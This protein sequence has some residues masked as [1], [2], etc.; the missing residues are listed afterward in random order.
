M[1]AAAAEAGAVLSEVGEV[2]DGI[3]PTKETVME[4]MVPGEGW[5]A[6]TTAE[7]A[8]F[9]GAAVFADNQRMV[10]MCNTKKTQ[11][12]KGEELVIYSRWARSEKKDKMKIKTL[13]DYAI[14]VK[15]HQK[16]IWRTVKQKIKKV[17]QQQFDESWEYIGGKEEYI[18]L[19]NMLDKLSL[20]MDPPTKKAKTFTEE[21][22]T[23]IL[24][25]LLPDPEAWVTFLFAW[26]TSCRIADVEMLQWENINRI[27]DRVFR[28]QWIAK[29]G[30][31]RKI[32]VVTEI[33]ILNNHLLA[34]LGAPGAP[35]SRIFGNGSVNRVVTTLTA[36][37]FTKHSVKRSSL[38]CLAN[39]SFPW[40]SLR[41]Q[42]RHQTIR[43]TK[44][45]L[46]DTSNPDTF[47]TRCAS[48]SL[49]S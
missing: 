5:K 41:A 9:L 42:A 23:Q 6:R 28:V 38:A 46:N 40:E 1:E 29:E 13:H 20:L 14:F 7:A 22:K 15:K 37:G 49:Q 26:I 3:R 33:Q 21:D 18:R 10:D 30:R 25:E 19:L 16:V 11:H 4:P 12:T 39:V 32:W 27:S 48:V 43:Q 17:R 31:L 47:A 24:Q 34:F 45:Y 2:L 36:R 8:H 44:D 35:T